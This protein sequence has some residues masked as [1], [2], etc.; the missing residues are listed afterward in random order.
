MR[1]AVSL[2]LSL[3]V[4]AGKVATAQKPVWSNS[5]PASNQYNTSRSLFG[6]CLNL[7][8]T[9]AMRT[10]VVRQYPLPSM[11]Q[12][13]SVTLWVKADAGL[14]QPYNIISG[15]EQRGDS[16]Y[17]W[18]LG[19]QANGA[20]FW[21]LREDTL[22]YDYLPTARRQTIKDNKWHHLAFAYNAVKE[23]A[24][25]YYDGRNVAIVHTPDVRRIAPQKLLIGGDST[26]YIAQWE[27]FNG[28]ID[29]VQ[30]FTGVLSPADI[31]KSVEGYFGPAAAV[32]SRKTLSTM[33]YNIWH[34]GRETGKETGVQRIVDVIKNSG[35]DI[36]SMQETYGSGPG[37]ADAL[38]YYFYLRS[39][40]L[41]ILSRYPIQQT[42][43]GY[44]PFNN[45]GA[46]IKVNNTPIAFFT[47]WFNYPFDYWDMLDKGE[48]IDR[49]FWLEQ[50]EKVN[51][52]FLRGILKKINPW[53]QMADSIPIVFCGD[54][55]S[56]SHLDWVESTRHLNH[57]YVIPFP[58][59]VLM[60]QTGFKDTYRQ[61]YPDPLK[62]RG[63]TWSP[64]F[65]TWFQDRIDYIYYMGKK[66][67]PVQ[68]FTITSH[69][70]MYPSD[71][72]ALVTVFT[73][74]R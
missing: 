66:L 32:P 74:N 23:E 39:S 68:S 4:V 14:Q 73:L 12:S 36:I 37:I 34:G 43:D 45:G 41:S 62:H 70:V 30:L 40:N 67:K 15:Y 56:G 38:G 6:T 52:A 20:W 25:L 64:H 27:T 51:T 47:N 61:L 35:A 71:H 26:G 63:I 54:F 10:P 21:S 2:V 9:A 59:T 22:L 58:T 31:A 72:A 53:L 16:T 69:P 8:G 17:G 46:L 48:N 33:N 55:N 5:F 3:L 50:Q 60:E 65:T 42:I 28:F 18:R 19:V 29:E 7:S 24:W 11:Q 49:N 1:F 44:K 57:G 13:F